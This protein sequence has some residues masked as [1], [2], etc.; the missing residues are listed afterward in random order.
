MAKTYVDKI[1]LVVGATGML[2]EP[3]ARQLAADGYSVR[4][5]T[6]N[7][8]KAKQKF[9]KP[10]EIIQGDVEKPATLES[11]LAGC[12]GVHIN[13]NGGPTPE[14]YD[15][16]EH[17]GTAAVAFAAI[18]FG[19]ERITYISGA[20]VRRENRHFY[21]TDAKFQAE[22]AIQDCGLAYTIFR[23]SWFME[24][25]PLFVRNGRAST[26]GKQPHPV[27]WVAAADYARM[28]SKAYQTPAAE[29]KILYVYGPQAIPIL[30]ALKTYC[31]IAQPDVKVS[32]TPVWLVKL[33][34]TIT[35][36]AL[37]KDV[38]N[39]MAYYENIVEDSDPS[40]ANQLLGAPSTTLQQWSKAQV[41]GSG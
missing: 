7:P 9:D 28:V 15:R 27:H 17:K 19:I 25:L 18:K 5:L 4:V 41:A 23:P 40:E 24:S 36:N 6:T 32:S 12:Y 21:G 31:A 1:I 13:L 16:I 35:G 29:D 33:M 11:A 2:G 26:I 39:L 38:A 22:A 8:A 20:S 30:E 37:L 10:F 14:S 34:A 3:V